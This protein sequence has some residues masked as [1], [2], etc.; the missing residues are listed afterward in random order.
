MVLAASASGLV[1]YLYNGTA[2]PMLW[3]M[4]GCA[5]VCLVLLQKQRHPH[6]HGSGRDEPLF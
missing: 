6:E 5:S 4:A 3:L 1:S 2:M